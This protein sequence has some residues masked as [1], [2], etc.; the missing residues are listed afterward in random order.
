VTDV[1]TRIAALCEELTRAEHACFQPWAA[2]VGGGTLPEPGVLVAS[3]AAV[4]RVADELRR[5]CMADL[6]AAEAMRD[7]LMR[8]QVE[9]EIRHVAELRRTR[10]KDAREQVRE[11]W[12]AERIRMV[13][14]REALAVGIGWP[15]RGER[16][17]IDA[18][19][20]ESG[21]QRKISGPGVYMTSNDIYNIG[22]VVWAFSLG[23]DRQ[24]STQ[25]VCW[26]P[27][28]G[29]ECADPA[30]DIGMRREAARERPLPV[31]LPRW[32]KRAHIKG[33]PDVDATVPDGGQM[34]LFGA[35]E[36]R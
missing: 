2:L 36:V 10:D 32:P 5:A 4:Q 35:W 25:L 9:G 23:R 11:R 26:H 22:H 14:S 1:I 12:I 31:P 20:A 16:V 30:G 34:E 17:V 3:Q 27:Q 19:R 15:H 6:A 33:G 18:T 8:G 28:I 21:G 24:Q 29:G 13:E 7:E